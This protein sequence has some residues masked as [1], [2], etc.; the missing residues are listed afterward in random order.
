[1]RLFGEMGTDAAEDRQATGVGHAVAGDAA[2]AFSGDQAMGAEAHEVLAD[3]GLRTAEARGE[4]GDVQRAFLEGLDDA[5]PIRVGKRTQRAS[6]M[7]KDF[8]VKRL[9]F[10]H[11]QKIEC[12]WAGGKGKK[13]VS[14][15]RLAVG[16]WGRCRAKVQIGAMR[17]CK[18]AKVRESFQVAGGS[19]RCQA[20]DLYLNLNT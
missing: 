20:R 10:R 8:R 15:W 19:P 4:L 16:G 17:L 13:G 3:R 18:G 6:A 9:G 1:M 2:G 12:V 7:A 5:E 14:G 11:I